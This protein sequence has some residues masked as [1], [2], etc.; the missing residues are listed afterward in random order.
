M[1]IT[2]MWFVISH[3]F[4]KNF[5]KVTL[6]QLF[7]N[8]LS[9]THRVE[10]R[11]KRRTCFLRKNQHLFPSN[12]R[13]YYRVDFTKNSWVWSLFL[14]LYRNEKP[15]LSRN[16]CQKCV[17]VNSHN[18]HTVHCWLLSHWDFT[19]N[20]FS[21]QKNA[22]IHKIH[23]KELQLPISSKNWFHVKSE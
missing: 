20:H 21:A 10:M 3:I 15:L 4:G 7:R 14:V 17:R 19:W 6:T 11:I 2:E 16:F 23:R 5:V 8:L 9:K 18:F 1:K 22:E 12:Q 13:F